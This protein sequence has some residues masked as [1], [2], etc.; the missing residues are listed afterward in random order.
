MHSSFHLRPLLT[1][2]SLVSFSLKSLDYYAEF[3]AVMLEGMANVPAS[4]HPLRATPPLPPP[5]VDLFDRLPD[6]LL[7][8]IL[9]F[10]PINGRGGGNGVRKGNILE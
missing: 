1:R 7:D 5:T 6:E 8:L 2:L 9:T 4:P 10:L 3:D